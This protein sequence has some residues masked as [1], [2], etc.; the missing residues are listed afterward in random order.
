MV[1]SPRRHDRE[2][3]RER[4]ERERIRKR[5]ARVWEGAFVNSSNARLRLRRATGVF[6]MILLD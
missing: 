3:T 6:F 5:R 4:R 1:V 2:R